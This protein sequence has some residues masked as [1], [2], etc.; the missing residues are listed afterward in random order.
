MIFAISNLSNST[1]AHLIA[2]LTYIY[3]LLCCFFV[4]GKVVY[5]YLNFATFDRF[6]FYAI[7]TKKYIIFLTLILH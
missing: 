3:A 5:F 6:S 4:C 2:F 7:L 1:V